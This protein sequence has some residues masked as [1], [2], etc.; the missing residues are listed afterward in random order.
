MKEK[1]LVSR[2]TIPNTTAQNSKSFLVFFRGNMKI[3]ATI[4]N[5]RPSHALLDWDINKASPMVIVMNILPINGLRPLLEKNCIR[6]YRKA[7]A[8]IMPNSPSLISN[9]EALLNGIVTPKKVLGGPILVPNLMKDAPSA[10]VR[11]ERIVMLHRYI[12]I[13]LLRFNREG[14]NESPAKKITIVATLAA[15]YN[16]C[17]TGL[18]NNAHKWSEIM[19]RRKTNKILKTYLFQYKMVCRFARFKNKKQPSSPTIKGDI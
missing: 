16:N 2:S 12:F 14:K 10:I 15:R 17:W 7:G 3:T 8:T 13:I 19:S 5:T 4:D 1:K 18:K 9:P 11:R 6:R